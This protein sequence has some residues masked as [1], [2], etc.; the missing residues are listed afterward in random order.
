L[1]VF[2]DSAALAEA[3][4]L[5][6]ADELRHA[7]AARA[8]ALLA[9]SGGKTPE[10]LFE[11]LSRQSLDWTKVTVTLVDER[12]TPRGN[13]RSNALSVTRGL[14]R[15]GAAGAHFIDLY[16]EGL[17]IEDGAGVL[18]ARIDA[19]GLPFDA[20]VLGMGHDGHTASY[21]PGGDGLAEAVDASTESHVVIVRAEAAIEPRVTLTMP[22]ILGARFVALHIEG[23]A[24]RSVLDK[25]LKAGDA[26]AMPI[27]H[28]LR[29]RPAMPVYWAP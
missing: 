9:F 3:L 15:N 2:D 5:R 14:L 11:A 4:A 6:I 28:V 21:F 20:I 26:N 23:E 22:V 1:H 12:W 8:K 18:D 29:G 24:K 13:E 27:R 17:P 19:A 10:R 25:A 16:V 7:I